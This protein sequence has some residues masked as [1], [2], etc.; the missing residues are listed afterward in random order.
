MAIVCNGYPEVQ[1][2]KENFNNIQRAVSGLVDGLPEK[3]FT[4]RL[5][6]MY[7][8]KGAANVVCQDK[9]TRDWLAN[10]IP[11]LRA[12]E[13]SRLKMVSLEAL[14]TYKRVLAWLLGPVEDMGQYLQPLH[15]LNRGLDTGNWRVYKHR[16]EPSGLRLV[17]SV[18]HHGA[19]GTGMETIQWHGSCHFLPSRHQTRGEEVQKKWRRRR[20]LNWAR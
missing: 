15:R 18:D 11:T 14:P 9:E 3:G 7:W 13:G 8:K 20:R 4:P 12:C 6:D 5:I 16:E 1:V 17:L 2:S 10:N 19:G